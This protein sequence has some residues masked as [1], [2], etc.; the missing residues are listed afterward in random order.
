M[1]VEKAEMK[2]IDLLTELRLA[3][4]MLQL[5]AAFRLRGTEEAYPWNI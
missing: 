2:D 5:I 3:Y 1:I 4:Q